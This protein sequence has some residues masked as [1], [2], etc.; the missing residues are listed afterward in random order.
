M[1]AETFVNH[2]KL[3]TSSRVVV[4]FSGITTF[5][6]A[7]RHIDRLRMEKIKNDAKIKDDAKIKAAKDK[8]Y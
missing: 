5:V 6:F 3:F 4:I 8:L 1:V 7:K 2:L